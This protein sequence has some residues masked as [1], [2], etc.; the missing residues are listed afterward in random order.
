MFYITMNCSSHPSHYFEKHDFAIGVKGEG[1][2]RSQH[3][4]GGFES[5]RAMLPLWGL[6]AKNGAKTKIKTNR[7]RA[8]FLSPFDLS[9][10][11]KQF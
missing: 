7:D 6:G 5:M 2:D 9:R 8:L 11:N 1:Q 10:K 4:L 3:F